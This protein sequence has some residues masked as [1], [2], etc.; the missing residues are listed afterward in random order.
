ML[1]YLFLS[2]SQDFSYFVNLKILYLHC[3][4]IKDLKEI[5]KIAAPLIS[6]TIH[7][8]PIEAIPGFR[9][10]IIA[11]IP[12]LKNLD[13]A[14]ISKKERDGSDTN[15]KRL[16]MRVPPPVAKAPEPPQENVNNNNGNN[17]SKSS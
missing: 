8:N 11:V 15:I 14:H 10:F 2:F 3:N 6:L 12:T 13:T 16:L 7:G 4:Y 9:Q 17:E 5:T 1:N